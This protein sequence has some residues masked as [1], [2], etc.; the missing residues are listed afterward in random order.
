LSSGHR[1]RSALVS[2]ACPELRRARTKAAFKAAR[3]KEWKSAVPAAVVPVLLRRR[4]LPT[5][6][7]ASDAAVAATRVPES[8]HG[9]QV[10]LRW[11]AGQKLATTTPRDHAQR[12][13]QI[14]VGA[15]TGFPAAAG[16]DRMPPEARPRAGRPDEAR[17]P[18][19]RNSISKSTPPTTLPR[20]GPRDTIGPIYL[21]R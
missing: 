4:Q 19:V 2:P 10:P 20:T 17:P 16:T 9:R 1:D 12:I 8:A 14:P 7:R 13:G 11:T 3:G 15:A 6:R 5:G 21:R 18:A